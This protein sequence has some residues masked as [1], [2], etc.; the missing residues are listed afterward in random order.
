MCC[1]GLYITFLHVS[2]AVHRTRTASTE[3]RFTVLYIYACMT[4]FA[5][6]SIRASPQELEAETSCAFVSL[7]LLL[8]PDCLHL[9]LKHPLINMSYV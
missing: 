6:S 5:G 3:W 9:A 8:S 1:S 4:A 2:V 7:C